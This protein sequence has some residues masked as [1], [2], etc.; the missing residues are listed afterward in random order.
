MEVVLLLL[1]YLIGAAICAYLIAKYGDETLVPLSILW[2]IL[3]CIA[4]L[5][6][7]II[8]AGWEG[9]QARRKKRGW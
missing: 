9:E 7:A 6:G 1:L 2:P 4:P 8:W 5:V 3:L